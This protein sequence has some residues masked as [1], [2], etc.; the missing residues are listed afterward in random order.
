MHDPPAVG[1]VQRFGDQYGEAQRLG[2]RKR[3]LERLT[4]DVLHHQV[5]GAYI[6]KRANARMIQGSNGAGFAFEAL[7][8]FTL[9]ELDG[10]DAVQPG[11]AGFPDLTHAAGAD[12]RNDFV[13]ADAAGRHD[14]HEDVSGIVTQARM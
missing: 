12:G 10:D 8:K 5:I 1:G 13:R 4:I 6:V 3:P 2:E 9:D 7:A 11:I 14:R